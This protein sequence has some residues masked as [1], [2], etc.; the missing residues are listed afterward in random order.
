L[1]SFK[2]PSS[3]RAGE[4]FF[5]LR[6]WI[7]ENHASFLILRGVG[8]RSLGGNM[9][10]KKGQELLDLL[11]ALL[12]KDANPV[13]VREYFEA[14]IREFDLDI[15]N[16]NTDDIRILA[17]CFLEKISSELTCGDI[18][19]NSMPMLPQA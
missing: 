18:T 13:E 15:N 12:E 5:A 7:D 6:L 2:N 10:E 11:F 8:P 17:T 9:V 19:E 14:W 16:L 3:A 1:I 4:G